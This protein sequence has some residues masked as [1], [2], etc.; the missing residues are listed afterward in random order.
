MIALSGC[1]QEPDEPDDTGKSPTPAGEGGQTPDEPDEPEPDQPS[2]DA[3]RQALIDAGTRVELEVDST[4]RAIA[5]SGSMR[6]PAGVK[7]DVG[8]KAVAFVQEHAAALGLETNQA[9]TISSVAVDGASSNI[10][11]S[12]M[13]RDVPVLGAGVAL[14]VQGGQLRTFGAR[15]PGPLSLDV[16]AK[17]PKPAEDSRLVIVVPELLGGGPGEPKLAWQTT[18]AT[19]WENAYV[20]YTDALTG[21]PYFSVPDGDEFGPPQGQTFETCEAFGTLCRKKWFTETGKQFPEDPPVEVARAHEHAQQVATYLLDTFKRRSWDGNGSVIKT[22][23]VPMRRK[24]FWRQSLGTLFVKPE[25][26]AFDVLAHELGHGIVRTHAPDLLRAGY[27]GAVNEAFA[28]VFAFGADGNWTLGEDV[29]ILRD[30]AGKRHKDDWVTVP[31]ARWTAERGDG[32]MHNNGTVIGHAFY[33]MAEGCP[34]SSG[35]PT[36]YCKRVGYGMGA[37]KTLT[38]AYKIVTEMLTPT[39]DLDGLRAAAVTACRDKLTGMYRFQPRDCGVVINAF[40]AIGVGREDEDLDGIENGEDNCG[41]IYNPKQEPSKD[42]PSIGEACISDDGT[43][44]VSGDQ[45][46]FAVARIE[47]Q[48]MR[49]EPMCG[50]APDAQIEVKTSHVVRILQGEKRYLQIELDKA[51]KAEPSEAFA[52]DPS[53]KVKGL[54][55]IW[56]RLVSSEAKFVNEGLSKDAAIVVS[57]RMKRKQKGELVDGFYQQDD[58]DKVTTMTAAQIWGKQP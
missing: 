7:G 13:H 32:Q 41:N 53:V 25:W 54:N 50:S 15:M 30:L 48:T 42:D 18:N 57:E 49:T 33:L 6:F 44:I 20:E 2:P 36:E 46:D 45:G 35:G 23:V 1:P 24:A 37:E 47:V 56:R 34:R 12:V 10:R 8:A 3:A 38:L 19:D 27:G 52:N 39:S 21:A 29:R 16:E 31:I 40:N 14:R 26:V 55:C 58:H 17:T 51:N 5:G 22:Y 4:G 28:D 43:T 9:A 11:L